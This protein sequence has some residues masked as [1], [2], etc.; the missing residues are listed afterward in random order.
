MLTLVLTLDGHVI[1]EYPLLTTGMTIGRRE[2]NALVIDN[3]AVSGYHAKIERVGSDVVIS[4][5]ESTNGTFLNDKRITS[6]TLM[7][8]DTITVGKHTILAVGR[9]HG[10]RDETLPAC[11]I[12]ETRVL[13]TARHRELLAKQHD[14][15]EDV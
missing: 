13:E 12:D 2:D 6:C 15:A 10:F 11:D 7:E 8:G 9:E 3:L 4:D 14:A 1:R 5:L